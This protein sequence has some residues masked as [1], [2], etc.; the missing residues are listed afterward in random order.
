MDYF[1]DIFR[2]FSGEVNVTV[3]ASC[4]GTLKG[5]KEW[6]IMM[7]LEGTTADFTCQVKALHEAWEQWR[8][9]QKIQNNESVFRRYFLSD[10]ANQENL[11]REKLREN[12]AGPVS[13]VQQ[14]PV[15]GTKV[16]LWVYARV[17]ETQGHY[18]HYWFSRMAQSGGTSE[19]QA[20][21]LLEEYNQDLQDKYCTL[22]ANCI[23]TWL[24]VRDIDVNYAGVVKARKD[25]FC[26]YGLTEHTHFIASTGIEGRTAEAQSLVTLDAYAV[27]GLRREQVCYLKALTHLNP[28]WE[29]GVTFERGVNVLYGDRKHAFISGTASIDRQGRIVGTGEIITQ[30]HRMWENVDALLAE[31]GYCFQDV[32][33]M[34]VYLRDLADYGMIRK[35]Y[36]QNFP[37]IPVVF[38]LAPVCRPGWLV[39]MEC[40]AIKE[41]CS[42]FFAVFS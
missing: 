29:Y 28:T 17:G 27:R 6:H 42:P 23:R 8:I 2:S 26:R 3:S 10:S 19:H 30:V 22:E 1:K 38:L 11:L 14:P 13:I 31:G 33:Q 9:K 37:E 34:I 12:N 16:A 18:Q 15:N 25:F 36:E 35:M 20:R 4:F 21:G 32:A 41:Q 5:V 24:F 7:G 40:I 39:E